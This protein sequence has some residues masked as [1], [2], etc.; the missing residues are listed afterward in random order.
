MK[1]RYQKNCLKLAVVFFLIAV[2][3]AYGIVSIA[4]DA[5]DN[6]HGE[7]IR[8]MDGMQIFG[9]KDPNETDW[10]HHNRFEFDPDSETI[11]C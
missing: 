7:E 2:G 1:T 11:N 10:E 5:Y 4:Y 8:I 3:A 6:D 9:P